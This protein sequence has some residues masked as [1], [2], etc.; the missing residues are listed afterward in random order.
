MSRPLLSNLVPLAAGLLFG[1]GLSISGMTDPQKVLGFLDFAGA[2]NPQLA[3]VMGGALLITFPAF[4]WAQRRG[5]TLAGE[6]LSLPPRSPITRPL[7]IGAAIFGLGWGLSGV[8]PGPALLIAT[9]GQ[10]SALLFLAALIA[11]AG[12]FALWSR[13]GSSR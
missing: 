11:G 3:F 1:V 4:W 9:G 5:K 7:V 2:W 12:L 6:P 8:C 10:G 13:R